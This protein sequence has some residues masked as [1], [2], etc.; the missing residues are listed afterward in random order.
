MFLLSLGVLHR[1]PDAF[2]T[3]AFVELGAADGEDVLA[4]GLK[5][6]SAQKYEEG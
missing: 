3:V 6:G 1:D 2:R 5:G 4:G